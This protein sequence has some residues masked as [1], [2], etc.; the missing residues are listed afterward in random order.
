MPIRVLVAEDFPLLREGFIAAL[1]SHPSIQVVGEAGDGREAIE[2]T[3]ALRPDVLTLDLFMP[4]MGGMMVLE[5]L[6]HERLST[7]ILV[8]TA[9][10]RKSVV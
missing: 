9:R 2:K 3:V 6:R 7:K 5:R 4:E 10:D 8:L 1:N